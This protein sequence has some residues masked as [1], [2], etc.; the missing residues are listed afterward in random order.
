MKLTAPWRTL[1]YYLNH[2]LGRRDRLGTLTRI[3]RWQLGS[4]LLKAPVAMP[5]VDGTR[6]LVRTGMHGATG[7]LYVGLMEFED[8]AFAAHLLRDGDLLVD[9]GANVGA[10]SLIAAGRGAKALALEPVP[11][12]YHQLLDN[13]AVNRY[14]AMIQA[15]NIGVSSQQG[16]LSFSTQEGSTNHVLLE[17]G[18]T[19]NAVRI[20]ADTLDRIADGT[21]PLMIKID[22]EGFETEVL[23]GA[24]KL[25]AQ[26]T[27]WAVLIELNGLGG[28]YGF[29]DADIHS[30]L[31]G[32]GFQPMR[33]EPFARQLASLETYSKTGNTLYVR[34][35][36]AIQQR[37]QTARPIMWSG[38]DI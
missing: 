1:N 3:F 7:N 28:R 30:Q 5:F 20:A 38:G 18:A 2:P 22:V 27:L 26:D 17:E 35:S 34:P 36:S 31:L 13:I 12:T 4:R 14:G 6:L 10:Y 21:A 15:R 32:F 24:Q 8:M 23:S 16:E 33:Y 29:N 37:L 9:V 25:L 11:D 19:G